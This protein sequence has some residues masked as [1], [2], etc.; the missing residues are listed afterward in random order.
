MDAVLAL[1]LVVAL[2]R[3]GLGGREEGRWTPAAIDLEHLAA[4]A[5]DEDRDAID[6]PAFRA[7]LIAVSGPYAPAAPRPRAPAPLPE[8][9]LPL[10]AYKVEMFVRLPGRPDFVSLRSKDP[11]N[12]D[13]IRLFVGEVTRGIEVE[14]VEYGEAR[15]RVAVRRG[16]ER[17]AY[18]VARWGGEDDRSPIRFV[19]AGKICGPPGPGGPPPPA[20]ALL[21]PR[22]RALRATGRPSSTRS[23]SSRSTKRAASVSACGSWGWSE[24]ATGERGASRWAT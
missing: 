13:H 8:G 17:F 21:R 9:V 14:S 20:R 1:V 7:D 16:A 19:A 18:E 5:D 12:P 6:W 3:V 11:A 23:D 15:I 22:L 4:S 10:A 2:V 24:T